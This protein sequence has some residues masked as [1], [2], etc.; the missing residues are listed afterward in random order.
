MSSLRRFIPWEYLGLASVLAAL[1]LLFSLLSNHFFSALTFVTLAN[2]IPALTVIAVGMTLVLVIAGIDL[3]VGSV[4]ALSGAVLGLA[5]ADWQLPL[6]LAIPLCLLVGCVCGYVN[7]FISAYWTIP[8]FIVSLGMLE[9]ARGGAYLVTD[10]QTKYLGGSVEAIGAPLPGLGLSPALLL[11]VACVIAGQV[12]LSKTVFGRYLIA[13]GTNEEAVRL[14]GIKLLPIKVSV[15]VLSGLMAGLGG[16]FHVAYLESADPNAGIGLE[17]SAIAAVVIGG[18]S[19]AG[20]RG[21]VV[22]TFLGV[23]IIAVLQTGL[24]QVGASEPT[25]R[26]I[27]GAVIVAAVVLDVYR[28]RATGWRGWLQKILRQKKPAVAE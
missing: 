15:F 3:S 9:I 8:S 6:L 14:S 13:I 28:H 19:L 12:L 4:M 17:L 2:Q 23:L 25:K 11:A 5:L 24:A 18:T 21:S 22:N 1:V 26:V 27:T 20:G 10:S 16:L 7:G